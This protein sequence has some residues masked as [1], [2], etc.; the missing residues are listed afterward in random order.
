MLIHGI[1][2][3][4]EINLTSD[5]AGT[6][7]YYSV[8]NGSICNVTTNG[9]P[10]IATEST[11]NTL[12]YWV[13]WD[14]YGTGNME[15]N[16]LMLMDLKLEKTPPQGSMQINNGQ[17]TTTSNSVTL[18]LTATSLSEVTQMRF[19]NNNVWDQ[20]P[21]QNYTPSQKWQVTSGEGLKTVYCQIKDNAGLVTNLASAITLTTSQPTATATP[22]P[23]QTASPLPSPTLPTP[24]AN[25]NQLELIDYL[26]P[27]NV[28]VAI[29]IVLLILL[30]SRASKNR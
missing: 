24:S 19:S 25:T 14:A 11:N 6:Q 1:P 17:A 21:W 3:T 4:V 28:I 8:N 26:F 20:I 9:Q 13:T 23:T 30:F 27:I 12:E 18:S 15:L 10:I 7:I 2:R 16:H 29:V 5:L 22:S